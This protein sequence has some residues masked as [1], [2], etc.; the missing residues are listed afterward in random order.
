MKWIAKIAVKKNLSG[1]A[2]TDWIYV[3]PTMK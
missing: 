1:D 2:G 3:D